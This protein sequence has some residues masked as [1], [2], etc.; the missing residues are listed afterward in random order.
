MGW[1]TFICFSAEAGLFLVVTPESYSS[2]CSVVSVSSV[3]RHQAMKLFKLHVALGLR[4]YG[5]LL[6][7]L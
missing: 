5:C 3:M 7:L 6:P 4:I 2:S 1:T